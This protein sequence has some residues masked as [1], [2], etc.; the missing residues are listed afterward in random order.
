LSRKT[1]G[2]WV[3]QAAELL[4]PVYRSIREDLLAGNYLQ[5]DETPIRYLD[6]DVKGKSQQGY[7]WAYSRPGGGVLFEWRLSRSREGPQ[8]FL[9]DFRGKL[10]TDGYAVYESLAKSRS[11]LILI[12]CCPLQKGLSRSLG[13]EQT[14][15][16]VC[17]TDRTALCGG[18]ETARARGGATATCRNALLAKPPGVAAAAPGNGV[19]P[20]T[21]IATRITRS[22]N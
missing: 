10:Q 5:A 9:K 15:G 20:A 11:D 6:P 17:R 8:E 4:K 14:G 2:Y 16:V 19:G 3:E 1:M 7:L 22:G 18:K 12:G 21:D 13:G